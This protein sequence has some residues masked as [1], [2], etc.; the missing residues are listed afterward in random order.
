MSLAVIFTGGKQYVVKAGDTVKVE[1]IDKKE[2]EMVAFETLLIADENGASVEIGSPAL[3]TK[4]TGKVISHT[5]GDKISVVK[6]HSKTRYNRRVGHRQHY[7]TI[8]IEKI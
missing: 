5:I 2:G 7:T 3:S 8:A 6:F 4:V 1:K